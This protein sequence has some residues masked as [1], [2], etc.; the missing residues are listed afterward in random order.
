MEESLGSHVVLP[1]SFHFGHY[2][3][4]T[5]HQDIAQ[6]NWLL[7]RVPLQTSY[8]PMHW[9]QGLNVIL[10]KSPGNY[11]VEWLHII[12]LFKANCNA[13]NN[14]LGWEFMR[15]VELAN[16]LAGEQY[17]SCKF[18]DTITQCLNKRLWYDYVWLQKNPVALCSNDAKNCYDWIVLLIVALCICQ[19]GAGKL[20]VLSMLNM[21]H[22]M[23]HHTHTAHGDSSQFASCTMWGAPIMG[24]GQ[25][26]GM[27]PAIW[28]VVSSPL[29]EIMKEEGFLA[30]MQC[31]M[32]Q[33]S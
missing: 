11:D 27:G 20:S 25:G 4:G 33:V 22:G 18:K 10:E 1:P 30:L 21:I 28:A 17:E 6:L 12:L 23:K 2:I 15:E 5:Q 19:L 24:I 9:Q 8:S 31:A 14:W 32:S 26:N 13:N 3:A 7:A 16:A 29:F